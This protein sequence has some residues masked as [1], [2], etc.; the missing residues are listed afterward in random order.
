[1]SKKKLSECSTW[2]E[3]PMAGHITDAGNSAEY[4]TGSWRSERPIWKEDVCIQCLQCWLYCPD[5]AIKIED[6]KIAG[7]DYNYCK[8]CGLC[9]Y[10]CPVKPDKAIDMISEAEAK[11]Q[12]K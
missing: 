7:I 3:V 1:M 5:L 10:V 4:H 6:D 12:E 11:A 8:G 2:K 9:H